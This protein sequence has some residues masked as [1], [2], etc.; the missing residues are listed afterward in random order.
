MVRVWASKRVKVRSRGS[1]NKELRSRGREVGLFEG[2][3]VGGM[4]ICQ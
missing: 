2:G 3:G 1:G 4:C